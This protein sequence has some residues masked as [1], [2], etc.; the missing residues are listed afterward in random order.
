[1]VLPADG[2]KCPRCWKF[3]TDIGKQS[4]YPELCVP[5]AQALVSDAS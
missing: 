1:M 5:C 3:V 2:T 4:T